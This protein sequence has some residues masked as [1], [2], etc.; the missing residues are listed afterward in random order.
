MKKLGMIEEVQL[1]KQSITFLVILII[2]GLWN[3]HK[4]MI[5]SLEKGVK[6]TGKNATKKYGRPYLL[7]S[8]SEINLIANSMEKILA[9]AIRLSLLIVIVKHMATMQCVGPLLI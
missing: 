6:Y 5:S 9:F 3:I 4:K 1:H 7:S 8:S 2:G